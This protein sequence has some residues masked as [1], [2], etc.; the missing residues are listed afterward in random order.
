MNA[1]DTDIRIIPTA[2]AYLASFHACL[3][4]VARERKY[5]AIVDAP[6][7]EQTREFVQ[8]LMSGG[9]VQRVAVDATDRVVGWC[10]LM[11]DRRPG[12]GHGWHLGMGLLP[13]MRGRGLGERLV[14]AA[15]DAA[16]DAGAE[17]VEL[18]VYASNHAARRLYERVGFVVEGVKRGARVLDGEREDLVIMALTGLDPTR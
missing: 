10:D 17:R 3:G 8:M 16:R 6:P 14:R 4:V 13:E 9:G 7:F 1:S 18:E 2:D 15:V 12:F 11:R 5:L